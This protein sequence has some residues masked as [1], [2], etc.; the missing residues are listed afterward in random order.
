MGYSVFLL[1]VWVVV[2]FLAYKFVR[3]N[4]SALEKKEE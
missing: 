4:I 1:L 2:I 3:L